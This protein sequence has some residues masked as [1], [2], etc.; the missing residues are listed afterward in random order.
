[1]QGTIETTA[2]ITQPPPPPDL[3]AIPNE[4]SDVDIPAW[5]LPRQRDDQA[6]G[7]FAA[8]TPGQLNADALLAGDPLQ[9]APPAHETSTRS[10]AKPAAD[11]DRPSRATVSTTEPETSV[12]PVDLASRDVHIVGEYSAG[13]LPVPRSSFDERP[14]KTTIPV[15]E[16]PPVRAGTDTPPAEP[17]AVAVEP[18]SAPGQGGLASETPT[19]VE[20]QSDPAPE[21]S[22]EDS[23]AATE[24]T[25]PEDHSPR[26]FPGLFDP[27][28]TAP[29]ETAALIGAEGSPPELA[30][31]PTDTAMEWDLE[32]PS[33][34]DTILDAQ[35]DPMDPTAPISDRV[36][37][38]LADTLV[39]TTIAV[40]LMFGGASAAGTG[41]WSFVQAAPVPFA[42]AWL[43]FGFGYGILFVGTCGQTLGKMAM[44]IRVIGSDRFRVGYGKAAVRTLSY[45][46]A[47]LPAGLGLI[48][49]LK[50]AE[51]RALHD[52]LSGTRVVKA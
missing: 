32:A 46:A 1:M 41:V 23:G 40:L 49:A 13:K 25:E 5:A 45:A 38:A 21:S 27:A 30:P 3:D 47:M 15:V 24:T 9:Q 4:L 29:I 6:A 7:A 44:R 36:F 52:R 34:A 16:N 33:D 28:E 48:P 12:E 35:R 18:A 22:R 17:R 31:L 50:D 42:A 8:N 51:H 37:S 2:P 43:I 19:W 11:E 14:K 39:L 26:R 20:Q 10:K